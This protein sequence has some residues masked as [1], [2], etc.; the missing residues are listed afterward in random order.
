MTQY[1]GPAGGTTAV[2]LSRLPFPAVI[3]ELGFEAILAEAK[4]DLIALAPDAAAV[5]EDE[6]EHLVKL[7]QVFAYRELNLRKRVNDAARAMTLPYA[8]GADLD[9]VAAPFAR[10][11]VIRPADPLTGAPAV[12]ESDDSLRERA[13]M[14]P[15]GYSVAGP[16]GAYVS[17]AR[18][19][20]GQVLD[21]SCITPSPGRVLVTVLSRD[22][23][24]VPEQPLL[25]I[26]TAAVTDEDVRPLTDHVTVQ[27]AEI[28]TFTIAATIKT[29][30]GPDSDVVLAEARRR[31]DDYLARSYR[32]G[33]DI[34]RAAL[35]AALC[36][37]GVQD[38]ELTQPAASIVVGP[39][40]AALCRG[41]TLTYGGLA[42]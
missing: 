32:L 15:E 42:E 28:L 14:G 25:D 7:M 3:E 17:F 23:G 22:D 31:L 21:A 18:A 30:A 41:V 27:A 33:R 20:S 12:M 11:L 6:S 39:T 26:V 38:V 10:R 9:V 35:T 4:A 24:G 16:A 19:A 5:L 40:Q 2:D 1:S 29:F 36:P 13:M 34:T 37:D 8:I